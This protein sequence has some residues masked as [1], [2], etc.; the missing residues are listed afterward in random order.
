[1][2]DNNSEFI[3]S[4]VEA[5]EPGEECVK[6][7]RKESCRSHEGETPARPVPGGRED[8]GDDETRR[9]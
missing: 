1:M 6:I 3:R 2:G 8:L 7:R 4:S 9:A 5:R